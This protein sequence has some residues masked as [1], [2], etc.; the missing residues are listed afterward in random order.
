MSAE[1]HKCELH[2]PCPGCNNAMVCW[3]VELDRTFI[4][5]QE[6]NQC[7]I[8]VTSRDRLWKRNLEAGATLE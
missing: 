7:L 6:C 1:T 4:F 8:S 5:V 3:V 2:E